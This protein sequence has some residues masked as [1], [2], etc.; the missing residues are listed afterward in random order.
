MELRALPRRTAP[1]RFF[2]RITK[3]ATEDACKLFVAG[4]PDSVTE[5]VLREIFAAVGGTVVD[6]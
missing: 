6:V 4:L 5:D 3:M 1:G 2:Q